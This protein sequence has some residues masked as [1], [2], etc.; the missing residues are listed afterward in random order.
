[1][2]LASMPPARK[3]NSH[4]FPNILSLAAMAH[5]H[6]RYYVISYFRFRFRFFSVILSK[7]RLPRWLNEKESENKHLKTGLFHANLL[8]YVLGASAPRIP[9]ARSIAIARVETT[10]WFSDRGVLSRRWVFTI[11]SQTFWLPT[12]CN[13]L[14][15][16]KVHFQSFL[17]GFPDCQSGA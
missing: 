13:H 9:S 17:G 12:I 7:Q 1:M 8:R 4:N 5:H 11:L 15:P 2:A 6:C 3:W 16:R 14:S 10:S